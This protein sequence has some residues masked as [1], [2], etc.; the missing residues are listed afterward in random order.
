M[1]A[2]ADGPVATCWFGCSVG[3]IAGK[4]RRPVR[5]GFKFWAAAWSL[6]PTGIGEAIIGSRGLRLWRGHAHDGAL[7]REDPTKVDEWRIVLTIEKVE[8]AQPAQ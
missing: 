1:I 8:R 2:N 6:C 3:V 4:R 7:G 5:L